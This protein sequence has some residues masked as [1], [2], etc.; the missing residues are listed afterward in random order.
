MDENFNPNRVGDG[1]KDVVFS[2]SVGNIASNSNCSGKALADA[3][4][5]L[6][7][8]L[9]ALEDGRVAVAGDLVAIRAG[10]E[11]YHPIKALKVMPQV[12]AGDCES[13]NRWC[14]PQPRRCSLACLGSCKVVYIQ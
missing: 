8:V 3:D 5:P 10:P 14:I 11:T 7:E 2:E 13:K 1:S 12:E 4:V 9:G 6:S